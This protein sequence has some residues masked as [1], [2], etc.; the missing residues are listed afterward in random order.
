MPYLKTLTI[1]GYKSIRSATIELERLNVLIGGNG[2]GKTN[3]ISIFQ[4][5][6]QVVAENLGRYVPQMGGANRLFHYGLKQTE[7][8]R[9]ELVFDMENGWLNGYEAVW[10]AS[11]DDKLIFQSEAYTLHDTSR[12]NTPR[13][14]WIGAGHGE[15]QL[16]KHLGRSAITAADYV[17]RVLS[18]FRVYHFHDTSRE[19]KVKQT[20]QLNDNRFLQADASNLAAYLYFLRERHTEYYQDIVNTVRLVAPFFGDFALRPNPLNPDSI[21][22]EWLE[23]G[24]DDYFDAH[25]LSDG[26]LRFICLA[27]LLL[28]PPEHLPDLILIDEPELGLH[29]YAITLLAEMMS[30]AA[31]HTQLIVATQSVPLVNQFEPEDV[32]VV[33]R[34]EGASTFHRLETEKLKVWLEDYGL[35]ELWEK[36]ILGGR[37]RPV[38]KP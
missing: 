8:L 21:R 37:P 32:I 18:A 6:A 34:E 27:T 3:L 9:L 31:S 35:G 22:L 14:D 5:L 20:G 1:E 25:A 15:T 4:L 19:A 29:P 30:K 36:N 11:N 33:D 38:R 13:R 7:A 2:A 10:V 12:Y 24:S 28:Q 26:T 17:W 23:Q 16:K